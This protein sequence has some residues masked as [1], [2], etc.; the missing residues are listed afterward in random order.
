[1]CNHRPAG[2]RPGG[3]FKS[4]SVI[5]LPSEHNLPLAPCHPQNEVHAPE[6][7]TWAF[8]GYTNVPV[9]L[10]PSPGPIHSFS[11]APSLLGSSDSAGPFSPLD[12]L[13][14]TSL[15]PLLYFPLQPPVL[16][17]VRTSCLKSKVLRGRD[18]PSPSSVRTQTQVFGQPLWETG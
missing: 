10:N 1:M 18:S 4:A 9:R 8:T 13:P 5:T 3:H 17:P 12:P 7:N 15:S 14:W 11:Q 2:P 16:L 6:L